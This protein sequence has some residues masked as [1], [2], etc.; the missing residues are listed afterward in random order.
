MYI[1]GVPH[2][3]EEGAPSG[4]DSLV[5]AI[6]QQNNWSAEQAQKQMDFQREMY[7]KSLDFN[8]NEAELDRN[9]QQE[10]ANRSMEFSSAEAQ[11]NR[12]WQKMMSDTA[13]RREMADLKA[14]GLNPIL[15]ANNGAAIGAGSAAVGSAANGYGASAAG[16]PSGAKAE[17]GSAESAIAGLLGKMLDNQTEIQKMIT[18]ADVARQTANMYTGATK[19]AA[20]LSYLAS[21]YGADTSYNSATSNPLNL[22]GSEIKEYVNSAKGKGYSAEGVVNSVMNGLSWADYYSNKAIAWINKKTNKK[23]GHYG[24]TTTSHYSGN[25]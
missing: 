16:S 9:F 1:S 12:N 2:E 24:G 21:K 3:Y 23:N 20:E 11:K 8:H 19:Y 6:D 15:A 22:L 7:N 25:F 17:R 18:S 4:Y 14:A 5:D 10:S 13:H